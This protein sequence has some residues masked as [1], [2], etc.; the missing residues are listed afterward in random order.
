VLHVKKFRPE[1][2]PR[3][4]GLLLYISGL[5]CITF[6]WNVF[7]DTLKW[8]WSY[9]RRSTCWD[10]LFLFLVTY[11]LYRI[12]VVA[13]YCNIEVATYVWEIILSVDHII[14]II[15]SR[16]YCFVMVFWVKT[17]MYPVKHFGHTYFADMSYIHLSHKCFTNLHCIKFFFNFYI[18]G[19]TT[20]RQARSIIF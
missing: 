2:K 17:C 15:S 1:Y 10:F 5:L 4:I 9:V 20:E 13:F 7:T 3:T 18:S 16:K 12:F 8:I 6:W 11:K 14:A 19:S